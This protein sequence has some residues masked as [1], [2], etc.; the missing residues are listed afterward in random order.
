VTTTNDEFSARIP[1]GNDGWGVEHPIQTYASGKPY[2]L[3][4][5]RYAPHVPVVDRLRPSHAV[6]DL[7][8]EDVDVDAFVARIDRELKIRFYQPKTRKSYGVVIRGFLSW[9]GA[10]PTTAV[11]E[12]VR[13]WLELLVDGGATSS[14][15]SVHLS[16]LRTVFDKMCGRQITLGLCTP[17]RS[18]KLPVV[19]SVDE[20]KRLLYAAPS[21]RDK[22]LLGLMYA[23]GMR[24]SEVVRLRFVDFDFDRRAIRVVQG[25]GRK[26]RLVML[27]QSFAPLLDRLRKLHRPDDWLFPSSEDRHR[28]CCPRTA[29]RAMH[30]AVRLAGIDKPATCH[31]LR[32]SFATHLLES[33]TDIRFIQGLLGHLRLETTTIYT[34]LALLRGERA[35]SPL[36]LLHGPAPTAPTAPPETRL[37]SSPPAVGRLGIE[38]RVVV[39]ERGRRGDVVLVVRG[40]PEVRLSGIV[41]REPRPG[42][43][44]LELPP[45]EDWAPALSFCDDDVRAR[46]VD[47]GF[48]E[49]LRD[50]LARRFAALAA[51]DAPPRGPATATTTA[52]RSLSAGVG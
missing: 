30:R 25:K 18:H 38:M 9:L 12:N 41:V 21:L 14:W 39:D 36:D 33:G 19:L 52:R 5:G 47:A 45:E 23:T 15:V 43:F 35:T 31:S 8:A 11:R 37:T 1:G 7:D 27:P 13:E 10:P 32:H 28:H 44:A 46:F 51:N 4:H 26:D 17:R 16:C 3:P 49:H 40:E 34:K 24:V 48:Y 29:Q 2:A 50:A 20:V 22:L 42:F 6:V